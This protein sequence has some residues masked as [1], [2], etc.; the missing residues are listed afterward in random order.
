MAASFTR[1]MSSPASAAPAD[2]LRPAESVKCHLTTVRDHTDTFRLLYK[3]SLTTT[4][5]SEATGLT[6]NV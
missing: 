5:M 3:L 1:F 2:S 4:P 6:V